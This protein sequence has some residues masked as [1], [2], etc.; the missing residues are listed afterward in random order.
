VAVVGCP[1]RRE[2]GDYRIP[3]RARPLL[4]VALI[5]REA[6]PDLPEGPAEVAK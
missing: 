5:A 6:H 2:D 3:P 1:D 4:H